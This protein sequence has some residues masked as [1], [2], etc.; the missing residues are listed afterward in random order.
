M[1]RAMSGEAA[2][3]T[4][5]TSRQD[6]A[7]AANAAWLDLEN[8]S[9][10]ERAEVERA[11]G[12]ELPTHDEV[13]EVE[14]S[15]RLIVTGNVLTLSTPA[16]SHGEGDRLVVSP[17][18]FVLTP[19]RLVTLRYAPSQVVDKFATHWHAP[20]PCAGMEPFLG[21]LEAMVDRMADGLE[22]E[23][24]LVEKLTGAVFGP[25]MAER[26]SRQRDRFLRETLTQVGRSGERISHIRD[27]LLG[28]LRIVRFVR[29]AASWAEPPQGKRLTTLENDIVSLNDY[30]TQ[31]I[32]KVQFLLDATLGFISI[33]QNNSV[34]TL[35]VVSVVG[36][37]PT[38]VAGIYGMNF[39]IMPELEWKY[40]YAYGLVVILLSA[41]LP[42][43]WFRKR[44]LV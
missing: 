13:S 39:K 8:P 16:I 44:G 26:Q 1:L 5:D 15:S 28:V 38:L 32:G 4:I 2:P 23:G 30:E 27:G 9:E 14:A 24:A 43:V 6:Q 19:T 33:E 10:Q 31:L 36:I 37:P 21:L 22:R 42:W 7:I 20:G 25:A 29:Q 17:L 3:A 34:R 35:T 40:G 41:V 11:T 18:G 12:L